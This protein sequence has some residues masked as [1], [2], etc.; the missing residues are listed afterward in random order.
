MKKIIIMLFI[1]I[2]VVLAIVPTIDQHI[3]DSDLSTMA[4]YSAKVGLYLSQI[5]QAITA[6][7]QVKQLNGLQQ[8]EAIGN[9]ICTL[10]NQTNQEDLENYINNI[11]NDLCSQFSFSLQNITGLVNSVH[12]INDI[13][14]MLQTNP[15]SA[16]IALQQAAVQT[17]VAS[18]NALAQ[19]NMLM[20]QQNQKTL[21]E[22]KYEK[23][24]TNDAYSGFEKTGL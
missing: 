16:N 6:V 14:N 3:F 7:D 22:Q 4:S 10:C 23:Q 15:S 21:A 8:I 12:N 11:N 24:T 18:Q 9:N 13:I 5:G 1:Y 19:V 2:N 17:Q 20:A